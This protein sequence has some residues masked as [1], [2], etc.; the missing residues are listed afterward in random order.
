MSMTDSAFLE[1]PFDIVRSEN[2]R[3]DGSIQRSIII[4]S[5]HVHCTLSSEGDHRLTLHFLPLSEF[6]R[7][8]GEVGG[9]DR[10]VWKQI[11]VGKAK[12]VFFLDYRDAE[13]FH[14]RADNDE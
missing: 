12:V 6:E 13:E 3:F 4:S 8:P 2:V 10:T 14:G 7:L 5:D 11:K 9:D 1:M